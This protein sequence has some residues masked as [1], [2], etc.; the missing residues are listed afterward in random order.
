MYRGLILNCFHFQYTVYKCTGHPQKAD[1]GNIVNWALNEDFNTAYNN[2]Q[3][4]KTS[5]GE[6]K[7]G[8]S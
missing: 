2:I 4:L 6:F 5:E 1:I 3:K 8:F 7:F